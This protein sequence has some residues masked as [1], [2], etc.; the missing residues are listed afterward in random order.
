MGKGDEVAGGGDDDGELKKKTWRFFCG[1]F[2]CWPEKKKT[3]GDSLGRRFA[4]ICLPIDSW[5][6]LSS[7]FAAASAA[8]A[9]AFVLII[10]VD[11]SF[12]FLFLF[13]FSPQD[14][15]PV[16]V[17]CFVSLVQYSTVQLVY[18]L[19]IVALY[20]HH[21]HHHCTLA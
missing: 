6:K 17:A 20:H 1:R 15:N 11:D 9:A 5:A 13:A 14:L 4:S 12:L 8:A 18:C 21:H 2:L 16:L 7:Y 19:V 3:C 10:V